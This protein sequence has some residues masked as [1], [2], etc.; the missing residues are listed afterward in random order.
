MATSLNEFVGQ[1]LLW[2]R[3]QAFKSHY[4]LQAGNMVLEKLDMTSWRRSATALAPEGGLSMKRERPGVVFR[5]GGETGAVIASYRRE[6]A[7]VRL[8]FVDGRTLL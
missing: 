3:T 6:R 2:R 1:E 8:E 7:G 5:S 4:E